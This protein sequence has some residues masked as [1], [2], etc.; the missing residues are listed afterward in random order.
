MSQPGG[1]VLDPQQPQPTAWTWRRILQ[2]VLGIGLA[3]VLI[4][5][6]LPH[7]AKTSWADIW[8]SIQVVPWWHV[9]AFQ[10]LMLA[11]PGCHTGAP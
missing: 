5:W 1:I 7:F 10:G 2:A 6:G 8:S 11:G 3:V 4:V 9:L